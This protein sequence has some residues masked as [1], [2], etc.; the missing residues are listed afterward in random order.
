[1]LAVFFLFVF[2]SLSLPGEVPALIAKRHHCLR[3]AI[4]GS[5]SGS[6]WGF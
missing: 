2:L 3:Y 6:E 5:N 4:V 1:M